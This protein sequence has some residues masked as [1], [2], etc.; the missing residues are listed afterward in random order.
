[1][2]IVSVLHTDHSQYSYRGGSVE[3]C[4]AGVR[5][6]LI[7][8]QLSKDLPVRKKKLSVYALILSSLA[9]EGRLG[10]AF[11]VLQGINRISPIAYQMW[12]YIK[13]PELKLL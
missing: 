3:H 6:E 1:M 8:A 7:G 12:N 11:Q 10:L 5:R 13:Y 4:G 2:V 9:S